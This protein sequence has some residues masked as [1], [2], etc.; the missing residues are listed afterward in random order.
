MPFPRFLRNSTR[1]S[2]ASGLLPCRSLPVWSAVQ[3]L[4]RQS[5]GK[6]RD[7][8]RC[9]RQPERRLKLKI[10]NGTYSSSEDRESLYGSAD[11]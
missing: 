4:S 1:T 8:V 3:R 6:P 10:T 7:I 2:G 9:P 11:G 5:K